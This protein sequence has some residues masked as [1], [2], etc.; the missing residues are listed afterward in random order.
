MSCDNND[1]E[2]LT[3]DN[4]FTLDGVKY[5]TPYC[6]FEDWG[7]E[8]GDRDFREYIIQFVSD[9]HDGDPF[10]LD[11]PNTHVTTFV[12]FSPSLTELESGEYSQSTAIDNKICTKEWEPGSYLGISAGLKLQET[13]KEIM[14]CANGMITVRKLADNEYYFSYSGT[15]DNGKL[16]NGSFKGTI[17]NL[18]YKDWGCWDD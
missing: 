16:L 5:E 9:D 12:L 6:F 14:Y 4:T 18:D 17:T 13:N 1:E 10:V 8:G 15:C 11:N 3:S 2:P 7:I